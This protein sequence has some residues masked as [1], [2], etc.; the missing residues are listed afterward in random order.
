MMPYARKMTD[1]ELRALWAYLQSVPA[2]P[3]GT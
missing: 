1:T 3:T 2:Q